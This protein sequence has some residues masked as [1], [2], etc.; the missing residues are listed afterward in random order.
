GLRT[1]DMIDPLA[2]PRQGPITAVVRHQAIRTNPHGALLERL[3]NDLF[4]SRIVFGFGKKL[5][6]ADGTVKKIGRLDRRSVRVRPLPACQAGESD[7]H[8]G[9]RLARI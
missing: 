6:P 3:G 5:L 7:S 1:V 2:R 4:E 8:A 9:R